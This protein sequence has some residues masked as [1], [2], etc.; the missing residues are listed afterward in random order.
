[1]VQ[2]PDMLS[3]LQELAVGDVK[4]VV[5]RT[6][7]ENLA[8]IMPFKCEL[9]LKFQASKNKFLTANMHAVDIRGPILLV[10]QSHKG[11]TFGG[12][13]SIMFPKNDDEEDFER[14]HSHSFL[15]SLDHSQLLHLKE[16]R[17][18]YTLKGGKNFGFGRG[19]L[20]ISDECNK[21]NISWA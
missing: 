7:S 9:R 1:M 18:Q 8:A 3:C 11:K 20:L 6:Q 15:F 21:G 12:Y 19:D 2:L 16:D 13:S 17:R 5:T 4:S 10:V 14:R